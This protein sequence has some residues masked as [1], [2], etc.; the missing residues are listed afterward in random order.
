MGSSPDAPERRLGFG[1]VPP[2]P[3]IIGGGGAS[4]ARLT[5]LRGKW[6]RR[7]VPGADTRLVRKAHF[8]RDSRRRSLMRAPDM[9]FVPDAVIQHVWGLTASNWRVRACSRAGPGLQTSDGGSFAPLARR[10]PDHGRIGYRAGIS[11]WGPVS[12]R[13]SRRSPLPVCRQSMHCA[14]QRWCRA[15]TCVRFPTADQARVEAGLR[16]R[17]GWPREPISSCSGKTRRRT[18]GAAGSGIGHKG[19]QAS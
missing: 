9:R 5:A 10:L 2:P 14:V 6:Q 16:N 11:Y 17:G 19:R 1:Q 13:R 8:A 4:D 18:G 3:Y 15:I 12:S 7:G